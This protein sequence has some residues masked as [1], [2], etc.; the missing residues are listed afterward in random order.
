MAL[1]DNLKNLQILLQ[2]MQEDHLSRADFTKAFAALKTA[3]DVVRDEIRTKADED[4]QKGAKAFQEAMQAV[5]EA[6]SALK[7]ITEEHKRVVA[8]DIR[9]ITR[10]VQQAKE[11]IRGEI[12]EEYDDSDLRGYVDSVKEMIPEMPEQF[13]ASE[14]V[15]DIE[16][17]EQKIE[18]LEKELEELKRLP[19]GRGGGTSAMGVAQAF[20]YILKTEAPSGAINGSNTAFTVKHP[21]AAVLSFSLNGE[22][23]AQLPNYTISG[24][25]ITFASALPSAYSGKDFEI[26]YIAL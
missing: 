1:G 18:R 19:T 2:V 16:E 23:I 13:D 22:T 24:R 8:S 5:K 9:T 26:K 20:K 11:D 25:T 21:I 15:E 4:T 12:P 6:E 14:I 3:I 10:M 17:H 7:N